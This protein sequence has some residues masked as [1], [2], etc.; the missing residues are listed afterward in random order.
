MAAASSSS[1]S[2]AS[3]SSRSPRDP[4]DATS[5]VIAAAMGDEPADTILENCSIYSV[6]T[7]EILDDMQVS[8]YGD[9]ISYVG[10]D[11]S[12]TRGPRTATVD[13]GGRRVAPGYADPHIHIDQF[14]MPAE[15]AKEALLCGVTSLFSD[16]I[17]VVSVAGHRGFEEF[18]RAGRGL[19]IRIF[20]TVPGGLPVD[21]RFSR[22]GSGAMHARQGAAVR[23]NP[24]V[25]G[26]GEVFSW[27]KVTERDPRTMRSI[28]DM[29]RQHCIINGHTAGA[30]G[31]K[32]AAYVAS[33]IISCHEPINFEQAI[34]RL[35][36]G[37][38]VMIREGSIRRDLEGIV[39][40][41]I[42][43]GPYL[44][45]LMFCSDG[46]DPAAIRK[47][48][49]IDHCVRETVR[50]GIRPV[51]AVTMATRN[52]FDYYM[53]G[54]DLG[55]IAPGRL[56]DILVMR[57]GDHSSFR[58]ETVMVGGRTVVSKGRLAV[59]VPRRRIPAWIRRTV[60]TPKLSASDFA[61]RAR[62]RATSANTIVLK[63]E[64]IT[65]LGTAPVVCDGDGRVAPHPDAADMWKVAAFDRIRGGG[66][67][68]RRS[69]GFLEG[70]GGDVGAFASTWSFHEN[71]MIV[72][73]SNDAEMAAAANHLTRSNGGV[74][75]SRN[76]RIVAS[77]PLQFAGI[78][79]TAPFDTVLEQFG[80]VNGAMS[81]AGC[82]FERP[83]LVP[84]FL[85]FLALPLVRMTSGGMVHVTEGRRIDPLRYGDA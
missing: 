31:R 20:Q 85:P 30:S 50:L 19:P 32:L 57:K 75:V 79:S 48:G 13:L 69:V 14:V 16:P 42:S 67:R 74:A 54:R 44:D 62:G 36:L 63:T 34:E 23:R 15:F 51:D 12:H 9:R 4:A 52:V 84:L 76:G 29:T 41:V 49:H 1:S 66:T 7:G 10:R 58:P 45:R 43:H 53:M 60:R 73:G 22:R 2:R 61:V 70:L 64:I 25:L 65:G 8:I 27:T 81:D 5:L 78:V 71:D 24:D 28:S 11:A 37:M 72:I 47:F 68:G 55:G 80:Q 21:P 46:L 6:Y 82:R 18:L 33:G 35:R 3:S 56:A 26:M 40:E 39:R 38:W 17:D 83:V 77:M 59:D